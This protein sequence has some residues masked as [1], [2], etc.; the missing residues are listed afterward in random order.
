MKV[1]ERKKIKKEVY[2]YYF[3]KGLHSKVVS[4]LLGISPYMVMYYAGQF[5]TTQSKSRR[6]KYSLEELSQMLETMSYVELAKKLEMSLGQLRVV[7]NKKGYRR[8]QDFNKKNIVN[9][10]FY[11]SPK[12]SSYFYYYLGLFVTD[13]SFHGNTARIVIKNEGS[14]ELLQKLASVIGHNH[15]LQ[16]KNGFNSLSVNDKQFCEYLVKIGVPETRKTYNLKNIHI[17]NR[18]DLMCFLAGALDGDGHIGFS[19]SKFGYRV[20]LAYSLCNYNIEFLENLKKLIQSLTEYKCSVQYTKKSLLP[21][22]NIGVR[23]GS[24]NFFKEMYST[25]PIFLSGK[26]NTYLSVL[27][28]TMI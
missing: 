13:G 2:H 18:K 7:L 9:P 11:L 25:S 1:E 22:L 20:A 17:T 21:I 14:L 6:D 19:K 26:Y 27:N 5:N 23:Q 8:P 16:L 24:H 10:E 12:Y 28:K 3:E 4:Q 15:I